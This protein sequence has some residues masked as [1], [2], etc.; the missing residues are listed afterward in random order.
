MFHFVNA[1]TCAI[2]NDKK[3]IAIQFSQRHPK[4]D[5]IG[6]YQKTEFE[7]ISS[8][9]IDKEMAAALGKSLIS[10]AAQGETPE[11]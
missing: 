2:D 7:T 1:Y 5:E 4:F 11:E 8:L 3:T 10:L 6:E 9:F